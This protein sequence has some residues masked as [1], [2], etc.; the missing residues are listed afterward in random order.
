MLDIMWKVLWVLGVLWLTAVVIWQ[1]FDGFRN[2]G[3]RVN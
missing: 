2:N 1:L 3:D